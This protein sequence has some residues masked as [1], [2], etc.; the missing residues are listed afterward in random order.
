MKFKTLLAVAAVTA[1]VG[2]NAFVE[3]TQPSGELVFSAWDPVNKVS[4]AKDLGLN[5]LDFL[6][7]QYGANA[8]LSFAIDPLYNTVFANSNPNDIVW[9][10][11]GGGDAGAISDPRFGFQFTSKNPSPTPAVSSTNMGAILQM[12]DQYATRLN[13]VD[14]SAG[15]LSYEGNQQ[16]GAYAGDNWGSDI[17]GQAGTINNVAAVGETMNFFFMGLERQGRKRVP[18]I[19]NEA[20]AKWTFNGTTLEYKAVPVPA[21][22]WLL[23][24][25]LVGLT[26]IS[27]RRKKTA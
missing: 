14:G 17:G 25:G 24:S 26:T 6:A 22:A 9:N 1:S 19:A 3:N 10:V 15:D 13:G 16:N 27:R 4:Y 7:N 18:V 2:A 11:V 5:H 21:A 8:S 20:V 12:I 23:A